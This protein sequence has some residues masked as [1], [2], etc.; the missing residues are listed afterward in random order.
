MV[1]G[2]LAAGISRNDGRSFITGRGRAPAG[3]VPN[4]ARISLGAPSLLTLLSCARVHGARLA[5]LRACVCVGAGPAR[6]DGHRTLVQRAFARARRARPGRVAARKRG[7]RVALPPPRRRSHLYTAQGAHPRS[8]RRRPRHAPLRRA[9]ASLHGK[10]DRCFERERHPLSD[11]CVSCSLFECRVCGSSTRADPVDV[12]SPK[13]ERRVCMC[14]QVGRARPAAA[15]G[16]GAGLG[17]WARPAPAWLS[18]AVAT[19]QVAARP[20][21]F[22]AGQSVFLIDRVHQAKCHR[23]FA[24]ARMAGVPLRARV[25]TGLPCHSPR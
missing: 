20:I 4:A 7:L 23:A 11:V 8:A 21:V 17:G 19:P 1:G 15:A 24:D 5:S 6:A 16:A 13:D 9:K 22:A 25:S 2:Y 12:L 3:A 18:A 10:S 14:Q